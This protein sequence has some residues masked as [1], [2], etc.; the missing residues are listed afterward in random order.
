M[1]LKAF[2]VFIMCRHYIKW[3]TCNKQSV[4]MFTVAFGLG[5]LQDDE[6]F[7]L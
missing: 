6:E 7:T 4:N 1:Y 3:A 2:Y 5:S